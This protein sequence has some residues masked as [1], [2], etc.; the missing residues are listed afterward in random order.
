[1]VLL[2]A[3]LCFAAAAVERPLYESELIFPPETWHNHASCIVETAQGDFLVCWFHGS[4]ERTADD[5]KVEGAW[6]RR[7]R[8]SWSPRFTMADT[9][10]YPDT[11]PCLF[12]DPRGRLWLLWPTILANRWETAL[13]KYRIA[14][15]Y[16]PDGPPRWEIDAVLH[17]T[18]GTNFAV[19]ANAFWETAESWARQ[20]PSPELPA[21]KVEAYF[22]GLRARA[23]DK[24]YRRLGWMTR[25]HPFVLDGRRLIV[26][27]YSDGFDCSL[28]AITDDWGQS[29]RAST[30]L[31][32]L[33]NIQPSIVQRNDGSLYTLMRDN[34]PP[35][36]RLM[37]SESRDRGETWSAVTDSEVPNPGSGAEVIRL[38]NGHWALIG[39]DTE[40][41]RHRLAVWISDDE[42]RSWK[43]R[44]NLESDPP[45]PE[46]GS[47]SYPSLI[48]ARDG[49]LHASYSHHLN[50]R[51]LPKD[52]DGDP[53]GKSIKHAHFNEAWVRQGN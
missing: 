44:R 30:P 28:M 9:P 17:L 2:A 34:G 11:N 43:W 42:G 31:M 1:M 10:G 39:N 14:S 48:Q 33:A 36:Q 3:C 53:A 25:A 13:M 51:T 8:K 23:A 45:G 18:P 21:D 20:N 27:L 41:G 26:P 24:L 6:L 47:Y 12:I 46:A 50:K 16:A 29:W 37:Q 15:K 49:S 5:V 4:G 35:P 38:R 22:A 52:V 7:G 32:G 40:D 19:Q